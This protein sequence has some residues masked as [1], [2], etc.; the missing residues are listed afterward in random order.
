MEW[1]WFTLTRKQFIVNMVIFVLLM[2][3]MML[4]VYLTAH[5]GIQTVGAIIFAISIPINYFQIAPRITIKL[6]K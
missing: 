6:I 4:I 5:A 3:V 2:T 1:K